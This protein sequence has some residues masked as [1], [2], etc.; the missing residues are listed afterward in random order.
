MPYFQ[1]T[2]ALLISFWLLP[3][4]KRLLLPT[5]LLADRTSD[6][7]LLPSFAELPPWERYRAA[8][9]SLQEHLF[10]S[11][12]NA[13]YTRTT[14]A[15]LRRHASRPRSAPHRPSSDLH[16][17]LVFLSLAEREQATSLLQPHRTATDPLLITL[18][19]PLR[20]AS[21]AGQQLGWKGSQSCEVGSRD[22]A[23]RGIRLRW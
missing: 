14:P 9:T 23:K 22:E 7:R 12:T 15:I 1:S 4:D 20:F 6:V 19:A 16:N 18:L 17:T 21:S 11:P 10:T 13:R 3:V 2:S 5:M 8:P